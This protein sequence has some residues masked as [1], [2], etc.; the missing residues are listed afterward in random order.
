MTGDRD[1]LRDGQALDE[2]RHVLQQ[3]NLSNYFIQRHHKDVTLFVMPPKLSK[4]FFIVRERRN[5]YR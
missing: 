4:L 2:R 1:V 3:N 5:R